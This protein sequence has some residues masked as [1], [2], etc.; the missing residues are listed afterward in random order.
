MNDV[1]PHW[2]EGAELTVPG[3]RSGPVTD[4][5]TGRARCEV[6]F[7]D[8]ALVDRVVR[9]AAL[10][11]AAWGRLSLTRRTQVLFAF[12]ELLNARKHEV[13]AAITAEHGKVPSDALGEVQRG[14]EVV[15]FAA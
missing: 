2:I 11:G 14:L 10:A 7:A 8:T 6:G 13:A 9:S 12:R 3:A 5:A 4:P 15:E 1:L